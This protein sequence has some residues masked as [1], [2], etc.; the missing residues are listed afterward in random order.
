MFNIYKILA[1]A[2]LCITINLQA[3]TVS[4]F[5]TLL[6]TTDTFDNGKVGAKTS[7]TSG[8]AVFPV[9]YNAGF[10]FWESGIAISN[11]RDSLKSGSVNLYS[12]RTGAGYNSA[13]YAVVQNFTTVKLT[14]IAKGRTVKGFYVTNSAYAYYSMLLGDAFAKKFG[15]NS[16]NDS[17]YFLLTIK[18]YLNG[19]P[20]TD[21]VNFYL[22]DYRGPNNTT[23]Y[24]IG[25]WQWVDLTTLKNVDSLEF[26]LSSSDNG[27]FG[28][29]TPGFFCMDNFTTA[30][31]FA[32]GI[33]SNNNDNFNVYPNPCNSSIN[34]NAPANSSIFIY[35]TSGELIYSIAE[36]D[37]KYIDIT[38]WTKG[39]YFVKMEN[40][41][42]ISY[43]KLIKE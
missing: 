24:L 25:N 7:F 21:S 38:T 41:S 20:K 23:D 11:K 42:G 34:I 6:T 15:G 4:T 43:R 26:K 17:D 14:G 8:N 18:G 16:G 33:S 19:L 31:I 22:A 36:S 3:Q 10:D 40:E 9:Y 30:D 2:L 29:N 32:T 1:I 39:I 12:A 28:M 13:T 5:E 35:N 37:Q 27:G